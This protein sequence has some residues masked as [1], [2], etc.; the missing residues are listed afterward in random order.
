[1][2]KVFISAGHGGFEGSVRDPGSIVG[3]TTEAKEMILTRD[4]I[5]RDLQGR[6]V[7]VLAVPDVLSRTESIRWINNRASSGDV[8]LEIHADA[9]SNPSLRGTTAFYITGNG[10][11]AKDAQLLLTALRH[12]VPTLPNRGARPDSE[13]GLGRLA[14]CR[15]VVLPSIHMEVIALT[16]PDDRALLQSQRSNVA[17]GLADGLQNWVQEETRRIGGPA[18]VYFPININVNGTPYGEPGYIVSNNAYIPLDLADNLGIDAEDLFTFRQ[19]RYRNVLYVKTIDLLDYN[20]RISWDGKTR[21]VFLVSL[22]NLPTELDKIMG[23]GTTSDAQ[24]SKFL[25]S[26]NTQALSNFADLPKLYVEEAAAEGI[27]HDVAFCQMCLETGFLRFGGDVQP[28]QNNFCGLGA[29]GGGAGGAVFPSARE[30]VRACVQHLK[31]YASDEP[32]KNAIV[33]PRFR[34]VRRGSA[35]SV[36]DLSGRWAADPSYGDKLVAL[37]RKLYSDSF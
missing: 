26:N 35:P 36:Y 31:A 20:I 1:M 27:N 5:V 9:F 32:L 25:S 2:G 3:D 37:L 13:S 11:R 4:A 16:N 19:L 14:F 12:Q 30:G 22:T 23:R 8:A 7:E 24:L 33:D 10:Q 29:V 18:P 15:L 17:R 21:T 28:T 6:K 34:F